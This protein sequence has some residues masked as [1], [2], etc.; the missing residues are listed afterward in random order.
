MITGRAN[1][2]KSAFLDGHVVR[3]ADRAIV[4]GSF[5]SVLSEHCDLPAPPPATLRF[6][7]CQRTTATGSASDNVDECVTVAH[8]DQIFRAE[9][10]W[11]ALETLMSSRRNPVLVTMEGFGVMDLPP[12]ADKVEERMWMVVL[13]EITANQIADDLS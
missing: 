2:T 9:D 5:S 13:G 6:D 4:A 3:S 11:L 12:G 8:S 1:G 10:P 7:H